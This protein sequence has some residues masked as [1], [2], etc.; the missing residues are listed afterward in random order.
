MRMIIATVALT[1]AAGSVF[2]QDPS[3]IV[4]NSGTPAQPGQASAGAGAGV[5]PIVP[6][7]ATNFA[8]LV[9]MIG[10]LAIGTLVATNNNTSGTAGGTAN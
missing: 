2:A 6:G 1:L 7:V 10:P 4:T 3:T 5:G 8:F 9:P